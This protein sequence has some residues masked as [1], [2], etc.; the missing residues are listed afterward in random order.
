M[1]I[2]IDYGRT[3]QALSIYEKRL[4]LPLSESGHAQ[5][6]E[7][8]IIERAAESMGQ[9]QE[10]IGFLYDEHKKL[11]EK[12]ERNEKT[13]NNLRSQISKLKHAADKKKPLTGTKIIEEVRCR[14]CGDI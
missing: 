12:N 10:Y 7:K 2:D 11:Q 5:I 13:I 6:F 1:D 9:A 3:I 14:E 4:Y 8:Q